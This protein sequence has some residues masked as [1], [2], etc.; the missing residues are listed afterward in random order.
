MF[1]LIFGLFLVT[2]VETS[3]PSSSWKNGENVSHQEISHHRLIKTKKSR[4]K[5]K[6]I[7]PP[8]S[9]FLKDVRC[10]LCFTLLHTYTLTFYGSEMT[11]W[12][13]ASRRGNDSGDEVK[14][15]MATVLRGWN[16]KKKPSMS[17]WSKKAAFC[18]THP[19]VK[20]LIG[21]DWKSVRIMSPKI[22]SSAFT[23]QQHLTTS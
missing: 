8:L 11:P 9:K 13:C 20:Y 5:E 19:L 1:S 16:R 15:P 22:Q 6:R 2:W 18:I 14:S 23:S 3:S 7:V 21:I 17:F 4:F 12:K 10:S